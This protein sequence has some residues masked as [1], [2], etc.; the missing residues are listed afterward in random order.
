MLNA[1]EQLYVLALQ[2]AQ[3]RQ[4]RIV[5]AELGTLVRIVEQTIDSDPWKT[6]AICMLLRG[7]LRSPE[8]L[9]THG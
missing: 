7:T 2:G 3:Y 8:V 5:D 4:V 1:D 6:I 9:H